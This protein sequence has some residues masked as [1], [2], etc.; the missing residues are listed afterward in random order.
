MEAIINSVI[1]LVASFPMSSQDL[2]FVMAVANHFDL[3]SRSVKD[4]SRK[5]L[6]KLDEELLDSVFKCPSI[7][8]YTN[9]T[10]QT[11]ITYFD[12]NLDKC[13]HN[14]KDNWLKTRRPTIARWSETLPK[15]DFIEEVNDLIT[16]LN[17]V[18]GIPTYNTFYKWMYQYIHVF[19]QNK[20]KIVWGKQISDAICEQLTKVPTTLKFYMNS[21]LVYARTSMRHFPK[22]SITRGRRQIEVHK[23]YF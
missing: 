16:L 19:R 5:K 15:Y 22:L 3:D 18:K 13:R 12:R 8:K 9:I 4:E 11:N 7:E 20:E 2:E 21:Y 6:I 17:R 1:Q 23:Y 10:M 14:M